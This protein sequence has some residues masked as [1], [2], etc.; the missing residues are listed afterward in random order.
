MKDHQFFTLNPEKDKGNKKMNFFFKN[1]HSQESCVLAIG[2]QNSGKTTL[3][4]NMFDKLCNPKHSFVFIISS[5]PHQEI[6][7]FK[8]ELYQKFKLSKDQTQNI[9]ENNIKIYSHHSDTEYFEEIY[10]TMCEYMNLIYL[11]KEHYSQKQKLLD[12]YQSNLSLISQLKQ[13]RAKGFYSDSQ[14][15]PP[16]QHQTN[17]SIDQLTLRNTQI[18]NII[19]GIAFYDVN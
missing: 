8:N 9:L 14:T 5:L 7:I 12:E 18:N 1:S 13:Q 10:N 6:K 15:L 2:P 11:G 19:N 3:F 4:Q 16:K 17:F